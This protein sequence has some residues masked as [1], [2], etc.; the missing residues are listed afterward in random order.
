MFKSPGKGIRKLHDPASNEQVHVEG[1]H[2]WVT[3]GFVVRM[4]LI[5]SLAGPAV[6]AFIAPFI[7]QR[8]RNLV[9]DWMSGPDLFSSLSIQPSE[10]AELPLYWRQ[11]L[12]EI[13]L[14]PREKARDA[15]DIVEALTL[16]D[17]RVI[18]RIAPYMIA[19]VIGSGVARARKELSEHPMPELSYADFSHL[20]NLGI[21]EDVND[22]RR[23]DLSQ[24]GDPRVPQYL[25]GT[26]V[27]LSFKPQNPDAP[28]MFETTAFTNGGRRLVTSLRV[29]SNLLYFEWLAKELEGLGLTVELFSVGL[30]NG[31]LSDERQIQARIDRTSIPTWPAAS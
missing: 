22:G 11:A 30:G 29:P 7:D 15:Q 14:L 6:A 16:R 9:D 12:S 10:Y 27:A 1:P 17:I 26:T 18:D 5:I 21:L 20:Q 2:H 28:S 23:I 13:M 3:K 4:V 8:I 31:N 25:A 24:V 19:G